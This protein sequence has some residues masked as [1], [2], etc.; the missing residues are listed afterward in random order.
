MTND[1]ESCFECV[2]AP[3]VRLND[4]SFIRHSG[5]WHLFH[6]WLDDALDNVIGHATSE[7]LRDWKRQPDI[8]PKEPQP[9]WESDPGGNAPYVYCWDGLYYL[10]YSRYHGGRQQIG[11]ATSTDLFDWR[12]HPCNPVFHPAPFW[13]PWEEAERSSQFRPGSC[14]DPHVIRIGD[15]FVMYYAAMAR[16]PMNMCAIAYCVS[17]DLVRWEDRGPVLTMPI[18]L[19][20]G[21][22]IFLFFSSIIF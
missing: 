7:D 17:S 22:C 3:E 5:I 15:K 20:V 9:S 21:Q 4:H 2:Y 8:L 19:E 11:L 13:C 16:E 14:R 12:K 6:I 1:A 18:S 10:F